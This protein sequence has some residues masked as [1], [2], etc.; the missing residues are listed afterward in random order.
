[1]SFQERANQRS[2]DSMA[3]RALAPLILRLKQHHYAFFFNIS[4]GDRFFPYH[5]TF[6]DLFRTITF[7]FVCIL[8]RVLDGVFLFLIEVLL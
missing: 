1:M 2:V 6:L 3:P 5:S 7:S 4:E 8:V